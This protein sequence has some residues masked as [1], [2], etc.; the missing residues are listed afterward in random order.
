MRP[1]T[2]ASRANRGVAGVAIAATF[3]LTGATAATADQASQADSAQAATVIAPDA[4]PVV[5]IPAA[6]ADATPAFGAVAVVEPTAL[7]ATAPAPVVEETG[8]DNDTEHTAE[9]SADASEN[10][11]EP[12][13]S[14]SASETPSTRATSSADDTQSTAEASPSTTAAKK[15]RTERTESAT[16]EAPKE[17][18]SPRS[19]AAGGSI[20][21]TAR[22]G[23]GV[24]YVMG[25]T[26]PSGWDC[27]GFV[28]WVFK[29]HGISLPRTAGAQVASATR[30]SASE[31]RP[32]DLVYHPGHVGIYVGNG[33]MIDAGNR[34]VDTT[35]RN[36]Y[37]AN[38]TYY[39]VTR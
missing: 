29:Q 33:R 38:W 35:E 2:P 25:G 5:T 18:S 10:T 1:V 19:V 6:K 36:L 27:S 26:S 8:G 13:S 37:S 31:A 23:I 14:P 11:P 22:N 30:I 9:P 7:T 3:A 39:R 32:G 34:R 17:T 16:S 20:V 12:T 28:Q 24:P 21:S 15:K 4:A